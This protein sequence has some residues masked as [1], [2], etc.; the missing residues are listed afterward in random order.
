MRVADLQ[1]EYFRRRNGIRTDLDEL[2]FI[3]MA[4]SSGSTPDGVKLFWEMWRPRY[5]DF[6]EGS[7]LYQDNPPDLDNDLEAKVLKWLAQLEC[8]CRIP[9]VPDSDDPPDFSTLS[10]YIYVGAA[11]ALRHLRRDGF[12]DY[13]RQTLNE[14]W[15]FLRILEKEGYIERVVGYSEEKLPPY[16]TASL[17]GVASLVLSGIFHIKYRNGE[18]EEALF[19]ALDV[20]WDRGYLEEA[21]SYGG[22]MSPAEMRRIFT[23]VVSEGSHPSN[24]ARNV[25]EEKRYEK[26][27]DVY[28]TIQ[29][30]G[31]GRALTPQQI[32]DAFEGLRMQGKS[33]DWGHVASVCKRFVSDWE[34]SEDRSL[35]LERVTDTDGREEPWILY[36]RGAEAW[37][38]A[39]L[40]PNQLLDLWHQQERDASQKRLKRYFFGEAWRNIPEKAQGR[41]VNADHLWFSNARGAATDGVLND[42]QVAAQ[43]MCYDFIWEPLRM[44]KGDQNLLQFVNKDNELNI[45][46][47]FPT[48][49]DYAWVCRQRFFKTFVQGFG[50]KEGDQLFLTECLSE[51]LDFLRRGRVVSEKDP[52]MR[53]HP[54]D[55]ERLVKLFLGIGQPGVLRRLAEIGPK[56]MG[57][58]SRRL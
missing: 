9:Y 35:L 24:D 27:L 54:E 28:Q 26:E 20:L 18:Y 32:V 56:L 17:H 14:V 30:V 15:R 5:V 55:I 46:N 47:R 34:Y 25:E 1:S 3:D 23:E 8:E 7:H 48:L 41:L 39:Q 50:L 37:A 22:P 19:V 10:R 52:N 58:R 12:S 29:C 43:Y 36:W 51:D 31:L 11:S 57:R 2:C 38:S 6:G 44:A 4:R 40:E 49:W 13:V 53:L 45:K 21:S 42:L 33:E 16:E